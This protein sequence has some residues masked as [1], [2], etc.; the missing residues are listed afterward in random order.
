M[1]KDF[2][3][4]SKLLLGDENIKKLQTSRVIVFGLGGV[5][6]GVV[7]AL[8]RSGIGKITLVDYDKIDVTNLNRQ[9]IATTNNIG[10]YKVDEWEKRILSINPACQ[11]EKFND[12]LSFEN[13]EKFSL[14]DYDYVIDAI[15]DIK[16]KVALIKYCKDRNINIIASMGAGKRLDPTQ[17]KISDIYKTSVCPLARKMRKELK[18]L[19][20]K[21]LKVVY[22]D[23]K[24]IDGNFAQ[25][26]SISFVPITCGMAISSEVIRDLIELKKVK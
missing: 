4:R 1:T 20:I 17:I 7:E 21:S 11:I 10:S 23:E 22:S 16:G 8:A 12:R 25:M 19:G 15:D 5:G 6:G 3:Q 24:P 9:L 13:I 26:P 18:D 14:D 2:L